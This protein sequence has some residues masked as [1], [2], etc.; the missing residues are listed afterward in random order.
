MAEYYRTTYGGE[1]R[2]ERKSVLAT[3][4]DALMI[5]ITAV[6]ALLFLLTLFVPLMDPRR[7]G[8]VSTLGLIAPFIYVAQAI[9]TLY[10]LLRWRMVVAVPM[11]LLSCIGLFSLSSF[12]KFEVRR[13]YGGQTYGR[14]AIKVMS[15]NVRSFINDDGERSIDSMVAIIKGL[16]P[17]IL[18]LQEF[19]FREALDTLLLPLNKLPKTLS[20]SNLSPAIYSRYPIIRAQRIDSMSGVV[21]ADVVVREDTFRVYN[22]HLHTTA[23]RRTDNSYLENHEYLDDGESEHHMRDMVRRLSENNK[24]RA[25]QVDTISRMIAAS[26]YPAIVCGDFN[27]VPVSNSYRRMS[28]RL[29]DSFRDQGRGYSHT[30]RGFFDMLRIDYVLASKEF[31]T[32]S[33]DVIDTWGLEVQKRRRDT[34]VV[35]RFGYRMPVL[36]EGVAERLDAESLGRL[37]SDTA[38]VNNRLDYSDHY[39]VLVRLQYDGK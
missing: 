27:D 7:W 20:R 33:Y 35:R 3:I 6:V 1:R 39:P 12:Y 18:C 26:P 31:T 38:V 30:Y 36:G 4:I 29:R 28:R 25:S 11:I 34:L 24:L 37:G 10:W 5:A 23:I 32:L 8:D 22:V 21:W 2:Q 15:Y 19:G 17:D 14:S 16:N 9:V 13:S